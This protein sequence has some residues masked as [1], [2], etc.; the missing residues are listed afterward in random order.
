MITFGTA[1]LIGNLAFV[2]PEAVRWL[3]DALISKLPGQGRAVGN[4]KPRE[5]AYN[6]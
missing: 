5:R 4:G 3:M 2:S 1:M 6:A